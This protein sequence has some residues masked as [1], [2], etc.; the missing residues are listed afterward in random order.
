MELGWRI[1]QHG[2]SPT[3]A[4]S[5]RLMT[6][7][8]VLQFEPNSS[9]VRV[10][11]SARLVLEA[12]APEDQA[13][14]TWLKEHP[15]AHVLTFEPR[16]ARWAG[17]L[18]SFSRPDERSD[19]GRQ[20]AQ[21]FALPIGL[22]RPARGGRQREH[23]ATTSAGG[24]P[25]VAT[26]VVF[27]EWLPGRTVELLRLTAATFDGAA[28]SER[29]PDGPAAARLVAVEL[30]L[31]APATRCTGAP[32]GQPST[33]GGQ[34]DARALNPA[35]DASPPQWKAAC[36]GAVAALAARG[37]SLY[38]ASCSSL[39]A[40]LAA[41]G[42]G[43][44]RCRSQLGFARTGR[45]APP[46]FSPRS[47]ACLKDAP[48]VPADS[49]HARSLAPC[50]APTPSAWAPSSLMPRNAAE[51]TGSQHP[52]RGTSRLERGRGWHVDSG[53]LRAWLP[54]V[55]AARRELGRAAT[56][57]GA[58]GD[59]GDKV[60]KAAGGKKGG[61]VHTRASGKA[62]G[63][64][65]G[66]AGGKVGAGTASGG[67]G[68]SGGGGGGGGARRGDGLLPN[69]PEGLNLVLEIG[70][71]SRDTLDKRRLPKIPSAFVVTFEPLLDKWASLLSRYPTESPSRPLGHH[72]PR[73][74]VL[75]I[76]VSPAAN[77]LVELKLSGKIDGCASLLDGASS[78]FSS[79]C[80]NA[81]PAERRS[82]PTASLEA[83]LTD[84]LPGRR[85][86]FAKVDAQGLDVDV[87]RSAGGQVGRIMAVQVEVVRESNRG[88]CRV[89]YRGAQ[90][91]CDRTV[92]VLQSLGFSPYGTNCSVLKFG[93]AMGCEGQMTFV[94]P[95]F[96]APLVRQFCGGEW[97]GRV[98]KWH[99]HFSSSCGPLSWKGSAKVAM[100]GKP[101][102]DERD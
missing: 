95:G 23:D 60:G 5:G 96:N 94:R 43:A 10:P 19:L 45:A 6:L 80:V 83:V 33:A 72:H 67:S 87:V 13:S 58:A 30:V 8:H 92:A 1:E 71:N 90:S 88:S 47:A 11:P 102:L 24:E 69:V 55:A 14:R 74:L 2:R 34:T 97:D 18:A 73:G 93:E 89:Q 86:E 76:A 3:L 75:P 21:G 4:H 41:L 53:R 91:K 85:I 54:V 49:S 56:V 63:K 26:N 68:G 32:P 20:S 7:V 31:P 44:A 79:Q 48:A 28:A 27:E 38:G 59:A 66:K 22:G 99:S 100:L 50:A 101:W 61:L 46:H 77:G 82:V 51:A 70:A 52:P 84:W 16:L 65:G 25:W 17:L 37:F 78:Y 9:V 29:L 98:H 12:G 35:S 42:D 36:E 64:A 81:G 62:V 15:D 57:A 40:E 39:S